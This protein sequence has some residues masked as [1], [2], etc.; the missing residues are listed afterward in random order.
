MGELLGRGGMSDVWRGRDV[1]LGREVAIKILRADLARDESFQERFHREACHSA[2]LN[3]PAIVS[4]YDTGETEGPA[5]PTPF[6]VMEY[7]EGTTLRDILSSHG[8]FEQQHALRIMADVCAALDY[9]H[10]NGVIHRDVKPGNI[11]LNESGAV[12]VMDFGIARAAHDARAGMTL[13]SAVAGTAHYLSPEQVRGQDVDIRS[14]VYAAGCTLFELLT[15]RPPFTGESPIAVTYQHLQET[16]P[17][18]STVRPTI[19]KNLDAVVLK[20]MTKG[21][22]NRYQSAIEMRADLTRVLANKQP[23][24]PKILTPDTV[25]PAS[26]TRHITPAETEPPDE[27]GA[28]RG[29]PYLAAFGAAAMLVFLLW[30]FNPWAAEPVAAIPRI[31]GQQFMV[32]ESEL[33]E[34]GFDSIERNVVPCWRQAFGKKPACDSEDYGRVLGTTPSEGTKVATSTGIVIDVGQ[35]PDRFLMP[36]LV[37]K[38]KGEVR[39]LLEQKGLLLNPT[40]KKVKNRNPDRSNQVVTQH[41]EAG[42]NVAQGETVKLSVYERPTMVRVVDYTGK[43][44]EAA[45][46]GLSSVDFD[47]VTEWTASAEPKGTVVGQKPDSGKAVKG[48]TVVITVSDGSEHPMTMPDLFGMTETEAREELADAGHTGVVHVTEY[49]LEETYREYHGLVVA[50]R[51]E[52]ETTIKQADRVVFYIGEYEPA[53]STSTSPGPTSTRSEPPPSEPPR[54]RLP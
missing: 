48:S 25:V 16:P 15:G 2:S 22:A 35:A 42:Y 20:A 21:A 4:L 9:S 19:N 47:V 6:I 49:E 18:P 29:M 44:E 45:H 30:Q 31:S 12:K 7:V 33:H 52:E 39:T 43:S 8:A 13:P 36:S 34:L 11:M 1:R 5:G 41:P 10:R 24:A 54:P 38:K 32:A 14:D 27:R 53:P 17:A 26:R 50:T 37:G 3:H 46:A 40:I 23:K 28:R 51:P